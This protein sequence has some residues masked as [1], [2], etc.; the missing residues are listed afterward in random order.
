MKFPTRFILLATLGVSCLIIGCE[1]FFKIPP[2]YPAGVTPSPNAQ[3][4]PQTRPSD[5]AFPP[6][7][8]TFDKVEALAARVNTL[9]QQVAANS[10]PGPVQTGAIVTAGVSGLLLS[11]NELLKKLF[12]KKN[13]PGN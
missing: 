9:A 6:G 5:P 8:V 12:G 11:G 7:A 4:L 1:S 2:T 10:P 3:P 13:P